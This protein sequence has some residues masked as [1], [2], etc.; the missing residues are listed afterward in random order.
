MN[1]KVMW[2]M[3]GLVAAV[4]PAVAV[5]DVMLTAYVDGNEVAV[6]DAFYV[7]Q[8]SNY[9]AAHALT[10][11]TWTPKMTSESEILGNATL[12]YMSNETIYEV[13][14]LD[15]NFTGLGT[16]SAYFNITV[17]IPNSQFS[18]GSVFPTDSNI[19][20]TDTLQTLNPVPSAIS[21]SVSGSTTLHFMV[22]GSSTIYIGF[23]VGSGSGGGTFLL[24]MSLVEA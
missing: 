20:I 10:G 12:G 22:T 13:N 18:T 6:S 17:T 4:L 24:S 16:N 19:Y 2:L 7:Q 14:V 9:A 15:V 11:F 21:L 3:V 1:K 23:E 5:A 8:G